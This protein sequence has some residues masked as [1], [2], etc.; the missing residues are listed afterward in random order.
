MRLILIGLALTLAALPAWAQ[1]LHENAVRCEG[2][3]PNLRI[4]G[5][6]ALIQSGQVTNEVMADAYYNRC[7]AYI[8]K[9]L[10]DKAVADCTRAIA[11]KPDFAVAYDNRGAAYEK[12]GL[13]DKAI[14]DYRAA[15]KLD[16]TDRYALKRLGAKP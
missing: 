10:Y 11:L 3:D 8:D 2:S 6:T 4:G 1:T 7:A 14:A 16:P 9:G 13:R 15:L 12:K 5:C